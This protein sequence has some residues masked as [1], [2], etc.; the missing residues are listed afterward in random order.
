MNM[1]YFHIIFGYL[2]FVVFYGPLQIR[3]YTL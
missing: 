1:I 2:R 3:S